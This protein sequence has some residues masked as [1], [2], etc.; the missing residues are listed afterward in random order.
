LCQWKD[1]NFLRDWIC[2]DCCLIC[3]SGIAATDSTWRWITSTTEF[4]TAI[5]SVLLLVT[6]QFFKLCNRLPTLVTHARTRF[7]YF[8]Q[9]VVCYVFYSFIFLPP[10]HSFR[11][12]VHILHYVS[13]QNH[14]IC[15]IQSKSS[16]D[17]PAWEAVVVVAYLMKST[18]SLSVRVLLILISN[19]LHYV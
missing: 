17:Y 9:V 15:Q 11:L 19:F 3:Q 8:T 18:H 4:V 12:H 13:C 6:L 5:R 10:Q 7:R 14:L 1:K 2:K 16:V